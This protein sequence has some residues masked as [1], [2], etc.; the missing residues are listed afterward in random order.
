MASGASAAFA[1]MALAGWRQ[2]GELAGRAPSS[3]TGH[4]YA[5]TASVP[6]SPS[7]RGESPCSP[8]QRDGALEAGHVW[9]EDG[10]DEDAAGTAR[11]LI[12]WSMVDIDVK[13]TP[14]NRTWML[15]VAFLAT[16]AACAACVLLVLHLARGPAAGL[17]LGAYGREHLAT[18]ETLAASPTSAASKV[19]VPTS[20]GSDLYY[21]QWQKHPHL[22]LDVD[23]EGGKAEPKDGTIIRAS[24][25][26]AAISQRFFVPFSGQSKLHWAKDPTFCLD[27]PGV[28][29][30]IALWKCESSS[31][32]HTLFEWFPSGP[33]ALRLAANPHLCV[34]LHTDTQGSGQG[35]AGTRLEACRRGDEAGSTF[36]FNMIRAA[37]AG[38]DPAPTAAA[39]VLSHR[40]AL[41]AA[42]QPTPDDDPVGLGEKL[43]RRAFVTWAA[44][45][46][47][48]LHVPNGVA[49]NGI[50]VQVRDCA[51]DEDMHFLL[52][53]NGATGHI[54]WAAHPEFCLN[55]LAS[56]AI[57]WKC[58]EASDQEH[59]QYTMPA[60]GSGPIRL[61]ANPDRCFGI[62]KDNAT[63]GTGS[64][65]EGG[66]CKPEEVAWVLVYPVDCEYGDWTDIALCSAT[67]CGAP[68]FRLRAR[69]LT[70]RAWRW[71]SSESVFRPKDCEGAAQMHQL[72]FGPPCSEDAMEPRNLTAVSSREKSTL[73]AETLPGLSSVSSTT[74][75]A[76]SSLAPASVPKAAYES[77]A[78]RAVRQRPSLAHPK[79]SSALQR[80]K[81]E[82]LANLRPQVQAPVRQARPRTRR[83]RE[84]AEAAEPGAAAAKGA[85]SSSQPRAADA[86]P[87][88]ELAFAPAPSPR[89]DA[90]AT[91]SS[92]RGVGPSSFSRLR[93]FVIAVSV[94]LLIVCTPVFCWLKPA[95]IRTSSAWRT[96]F[97]PRR[98]GPPLSAKP[99]VMTGQGANRE[100]RSMGSPCSSQ[101]HF[102]VHPNRTS[103]DTLPT[104]RMVLI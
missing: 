87:S 14:V 6:C 62:P 84:E 42:A 59:L 70:R 28:G 72:C 67:A 41:A 68:G 24:R 93:D 56:G 16:C 100:L 101:A 92:E 90:N 81:E 65:V 52:P 21:I 69:P 82:T 103:L 39:R 57:L 98:I 46:T 22:C 55:S 53:E 104:T 12:R 2:L 63:I 77:P 36:T 99:S 73:G 49:E 48:C 23:L 4:S 85:E 97:R 37:T 3:R 15:S 38:F 10:L 83:R 102:T 25:C 40:E 30:N 74:L 45:P 1:A 88:E 18:S 20:S 79:L 54:R 7:G 78:G 26:N 27:A 31:N 19:G 44:H 80:L 9:A 11:K 71:S 35:T 58:D 86:R 75:A 43:G 60:K 50:A 91:S 34:G 66:P 8:S 76:T 61:A 94:G 95:L 51:E 32:F 47:K 29:K 96:R 5:L 33:G 64:L 89:G 17:A 13:G